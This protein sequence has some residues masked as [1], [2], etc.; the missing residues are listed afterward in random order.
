[1][2]ELVFEQ[3]SGVF[4]SRC[5]WHMIRSCV[6]RISLRSPPGGELSL[7]IEETRVDGDTQMKE[8]GEKAEKAEIKRDQECVQ[9]KKPFTSFSYATDHYSQISYQQENTA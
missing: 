9:R 8:E 6:N 7:D 4:G 3:V 2:L 1:M 5:V